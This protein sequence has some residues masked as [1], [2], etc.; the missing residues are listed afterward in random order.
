[1]VT[2]TALRSNKNYEFESLHQET[3]MG[4]KLIVFTGTLQ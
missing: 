2:N 1:M 3:I 4:L